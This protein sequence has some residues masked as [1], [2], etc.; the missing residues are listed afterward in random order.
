[1]HGAECDMATDTSTSGSRHCMALVG[2]IDPDAGGSIVDVYED[3]SGQS[4]RLRVLM[5][6]FL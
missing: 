3:G 4:V 5:S 1:M 6:F 2:F